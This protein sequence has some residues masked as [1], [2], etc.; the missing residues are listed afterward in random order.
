MPMPTEEIQAN[1]FRDNYT[2]S[3]DMCRGAFPRRHKVAKRDGRMEEGLI[4]DG[5]VPGVRLYRSEEKAREHH[6][7]D[8]EL[9]TV[10]RD[11]EDFYKPQL[12][13]DG[14]S[15]YEQTSDVTERAM[16]AEAEFLEEK[17]GLVGSKLE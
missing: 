3:R 17:E 8:V 6:G 4:P 9:R 5:G 13:T 1:Q 16:R 2:D 14:G 7:E 15:E 10:R 11:G 12:E